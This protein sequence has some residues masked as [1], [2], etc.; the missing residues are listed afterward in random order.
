ML[1]EACLSDGFHPNA[2]HQYGLIR[3]TSRGDMCALAEELTGNVTMFY[4]FG[5]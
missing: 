5:A 2:L 3:F 1:K 4:F